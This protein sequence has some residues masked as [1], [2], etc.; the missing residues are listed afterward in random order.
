VIPISHARITGLALVLV[1]SATACTTTP[2]TRTPPPVI[3]RGVPAPERPPARE[4]A[5][6]PGEYQKLPGVQTYPAPREQ[7]AAVVALLGHAEQQA[8]NGDL[9]AAAMTL[10]RAIRIDPR[11]PVLWHH[12]ASVRLAEGNAEQAEGLAKKSNALAAGNYALQA[13]NWGLIAAARRA[14]GDTSGAQSAERQK[15]SLQAR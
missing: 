3:E 10:E 14:R 15:Q 13:R 2:Y 8:N 11:N 9:P 5:V 7:P 1:V 4:E 12:L 6:P